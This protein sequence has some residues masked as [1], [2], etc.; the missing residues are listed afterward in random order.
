M[1]GRDR[2]HLGAL[3]PAG[4]EYR[5]QSQKQEKSRLTH[6]LSSDL[7]TYTMAYA[8]V[9]THNKQTSKQINIYL[10]KL[11]Q[12]GKTCTLKLQYFTEKSK[13]PNKEKILYVHLFKDLFEDF[14]TLQMFCRFNERAFFNG[15]EN[16]ILKFIW[17][18]KGL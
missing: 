17:D 5:A 11:S 18:F 8:Y 12:G 1:G 10:K 13:D 7:H 6:S 4:L 14:Q 16:L 2:N 9:H 3:K 15:V